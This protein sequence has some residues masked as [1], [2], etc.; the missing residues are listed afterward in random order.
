MELNA[1]QRQALELMKSGQYM[2]MMELAAAPAHERAAL[3]STASSTA[4]R[5]ASSV[6]PLLGWRQAI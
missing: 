4:T 2:S 1:E 3:S 5:T 6:L